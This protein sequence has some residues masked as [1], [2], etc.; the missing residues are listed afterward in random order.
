M[1]WLESRGPFDAR[2]FGASVLRA[3]VAGAVFAIGYITLGKNIGLMDIVIAFVA[4]AGFDVLG[5]RIAGSIK[6]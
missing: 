2:K 4:G 6:V 1:G 5:H 3:L